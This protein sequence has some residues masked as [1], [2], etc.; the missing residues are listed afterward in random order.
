M[1]NRL[2]AT[3]N[4]MLRTTTTTTYRNIPTLRESASTASTTVPYLEAQLLNQTAFNIKC[5][6]V[7]GTEF[8]FGDGDSVFAAIFAVLF[9]I[10]GICLNLLVIVAL[11]HSRRTR[12]HPT[13]PFI[14]SLTVSDL[15]Y[16]GMILPIMAA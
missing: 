15:V 16:S 12:R 2:R 8:V 13:T 11:I 3:T 14:I 10:A 5:P 6:S 1:A 9:S 4:W 7:G